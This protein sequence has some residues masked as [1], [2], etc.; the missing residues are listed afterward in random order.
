[1]SLLLL[2]RFL[3]TEPS[4]QKTP[5]S[6]LK[7]RARGLLATGFQ[8]RNYYAMVTVLAVES[9][10][11]GYLIFRVGVPVATAMKMPG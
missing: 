5:R 3:E 2:N 1:M 9:V 6:R 4:A 11:P 8:V 7:E 10:A